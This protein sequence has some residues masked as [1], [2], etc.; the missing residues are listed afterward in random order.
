MRPALRLV[1]LAVIAFAVASPSSG[2]AAV[3][4]D[5][6]PVAS[7]VVV[8]GCEMAM[9]M[10]E[11][12]P[13]PE[14][15]DDI[16][17]TALDLDVL[18]VDVLIPH[19]EMAVTMAEIARSRSNRPEVVSLATGIVEAQSRE[20]EQLRAW[21][22]VWYPDVPA[23]SET[24]VFAG[25]ETKAASPGRGGAPGLDDL[26]MAGMAAA[27]AELCEETELFDLVF[28]DEMVEHHTGA[29][30]ISELVAADAVHHELRTFARTVVDIQ[31]GEIATMLGWRDAWYGGYPADH[32]GGDEATPAG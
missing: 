26:T 31:G 7:P 4:Q 14:A 18:Y 9:P 29:V 23:L 17:P 1:V 27:M 32:D 25:L 24:Q 20:I 5:A 6:S 28:I 13:V 11:G 15:A 3:A 8:D 19:H 30:L 10:G 21:R 12:T 22:E 2:G 16:D